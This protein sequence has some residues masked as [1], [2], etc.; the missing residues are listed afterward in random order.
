MYFS[1]FYPWQIISRAF[2]LDMACKLPVVFDKEALEDEVSA[3][4][5]QYGAKKQF[6]GY[7]D[8]GWTAIGLMASGGNYLDDQVTTNIQKTDP[9][10]IAPYLNSIIDSF[11]VPTGRVRLMQL[12][13]GERIHWHFDHS[14]VFPGKSVRLH[15]PVFTN[16]Q[17]R[18]QIGHQDLFWGPGETWFGDFSFPHRVINGGATPRIH[19]VLDLKFEDQIRPLFPSKM[20]EQIQARK[21]AQYLSRRAYILCTPKVL[22][23]KVAER[24]T[25]LLS[26]VH[27]W[28]TAR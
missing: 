10:R 15:I 17:V 25:Q 12:G 16:D 5:T 11:E 18:L 19:L 14:F 28:P 23:K 6:G 20:F 24:V 4:L 3:I 2:N 7:H 21:S 13:P 1:N 26:S 22:A 9:L 27:S 8:G